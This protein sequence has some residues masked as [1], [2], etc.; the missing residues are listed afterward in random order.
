MPRYWLSRLIAACWAGHLPL[1]TWLAPQSLSAR[2]L[3]ESGPTGF[4]V[5]VLLMACALVA[6]VDVA[7]TNLLP[8]RF[9]PFTA[10]HRHVGFLAMAILLAMLAFAIAAGGAHLPVLI[11]YLT[12]CGFCVWVAFLDLAARHQ[13]RRK[14]RS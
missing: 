7:A 11:S 13:Q 5:M 2:A 12:A 14:T 8:P 10:R 6:I 3:S 4:Y 9:H 1:V